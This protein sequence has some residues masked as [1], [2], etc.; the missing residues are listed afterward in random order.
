MAALQPPPRVALLGSNGLP[1]QA[2]RDFFLAAATQI[3]TGLAP[4]DARYLLSA[5]N[6][7]L[8]QAFNLGALL[9][10]YL[11]LTTALGVGT[12]ST[13]PTIPASDLSGTV[14]IAHG[15]TNGTAVPALGAVAYGTGASY[16]FSG[17]GS[18]GQLLV[19]AGAAVP[20]WTAVATAIAH[21]LLDG[22]V[23]NDTLAAA[24]ARGAVIVGNATPKWARVTVGGAK[25]VLRSDGTDTAFTQLQASDLSDVASGT[26]T[27]T[28][29]NV[30][31]L[32]ASTAFTCQYLRVGSMVTVSGKVDIDPTT[33]LTLTQ[34]GMSLPIASNFATAQQCGGTAAAATVAGSV[35]AVLADPVNDRAEFDVIPVS[36]ANHS[37]WFNFSYWLV[38]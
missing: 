15:G 3:Q 35:A 12:P 28:L 26:F 7:E 4:S 37:M 10:G 14:P 33:T 30:A 36:V 38:L 20:V 21:A 29:Y 17:I 18:A 24:P 8:T 9:T 19:S 32:D 1:T 31:N 27:P 5:P 23:D 34:L 6:A 11:K 22:T 25:T 16:G 13:T 2:W